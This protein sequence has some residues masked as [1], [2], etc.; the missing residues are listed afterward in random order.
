MKILVTGGAGFIG[1]HTVDSLLA[2]GHKVRILDN[3]QKPVHLKGKPSYLADE[4]EFMLGDVR[5]K[6][7]WQRALQQI[8]AVYHL[9]A[10][11]DYLPDF[12]TF[13]HVNVVG[14]ALLYEVAVEKK[15]DL[16]K[17]VVA[18]SQ[19][20]YGE[21]KYCCKQCNTEGFAPLRHKNRLSKGEWDIFC[22][23]CN[24][25]MVYI[26]GQENWADPQ[27]QY[28]ISKYTQETLALNL[29]RRYE[30]PTVAMR[31]SIVQGAR[32]S[33][34]NAYSG[35]NRIFSLS[36]F[37]KKSP[38]IYEDGKQLR[39]FVNISDVVA[40]NLLVLN[41][42]GANYKVLNVGGGKT[43]TVLEFY[44]IVQKI[45]DVDIPPRLEGNFR[46]GDTRNAI[47]DITA[48]KC[49][50]WEPKNSAE[51]SVL[52]YRHYLEE[53]TDIEDILDYSEKMMKKKNVVVYSETSNVKRE[54]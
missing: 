34:Y 39:D 41:K 37:L 3:L 6:P 48:L 18:S 7:D 42:D 11:Q 44:N 14:T 21:G 5:S 40:A 43:Y 26:P 38:P 35:A 10:Y 4:A 9:A 31:Y 28:A 52:D 27:N 22:S 23:V 32:Q 20:A 8:D 25:E 51:K 12:S 19:A 29:G 50:G 54:K 15:M 2:E 17:V 1:S 45:F 33:F 16:K 24:Q 53:Q 47:S 13:F 49:M 30:I 46:V 36:A